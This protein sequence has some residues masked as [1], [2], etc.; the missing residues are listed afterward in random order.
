MPPRGGFTWNPYATTSRAPRPVSWSSTG[1]RNVKPGEDFQCDVSLPESPAAGRQPGW[2]LGRKYRQPSPTTWLDVATEADYEFV[3]ALGGSAEANSEIEGILNVVGG[4]YQSEL[5]LKLQISFQNAWAAEEDPYTAST[6]AGLETE[7][8][9]YWKENYEEDQDYDLVLFWTGRQ[10]LNALGRYSGRVCYTDEAYQPPVFLAGLRPNWGDWDGTQKYQLAAHGIGHLF[11]ATHPTDQ[12]PRNVPCAQTIMHIGGRGLTFCQFSRDE[13][14]SHLASNNGCLDTQTIILQPPSSL[15]ATSVSSSSISLS[16]QDNST[17]ETGFIVQRRRF[18]SG[19]WVQIGTTAADT[20][21]FSNDRLFSEYPYIFRVQALNDSE[22]SAYSNEAEATTPAGTLVIADWRIH[23]IAG[24]DDGDDGPALQAHLE[25]P[26]S[27][28]VDSAGNLYISDYFSNRIRR[29]DTSGTITTIAGTGTRG[30]TGDGGAATGANLNRPGGQAVDNSGNLYIVDGGNHRIRKVD[31]SG[32]ITTVAGTGVRGYSGDGGNAVEAQLAPASVAVDS[33]GN[34][35][36]SDS[37]N[38]RI[39]KVDTSG[40][41]TTVAGTGV[42]GYSGDGGKAVE[43]RLNYPASVEVDTSGNLY[44]TDSSNERIRKVDTSGIITTVAGNGEEGYSGD[45]GPAVEARLESPSG[46]AV[47]GA[48]NL[49]IADPSTHRIR[50]V[51]TSGTITTVAGTGSLGYSGDGGPATGARLYQPGDVAVDSSGNLYI[52]DGLNH[53][54]RKVDTSGIITTAAGGGG[55]YTGDGGLAT[56]ARLNNPGGMALDSSGNLYIADSDHHRIRKVDTSGII[57]TFAGAGERGYSGDGGPAVSAKLAWPRGVAV[58][59]AGNLY[60]ADAGNHRVRRVNSQGIITTVSKGSPTGVVVDASGNLYIADSSYNRIRRL[61]TSGTLTTIAGTGSQGFS[62]DGGPAVEAELRVPNDL[63]VDASGNLYIADTWNRRIRKVDSSGTITTVAGAGL[64]VNSG[65]YGPATEA[66]L[67]WP[68]GVA[69]DGS[70]NLYIPDATPGRIKRVDTSG[71]LTTIA[72]TGVSGF[73]GDGGPAIQAQLHRPLRVAVDSSGNVYI[74]DS[75]N[76]RIRILSTDTTAPTVE[77]IAIASEPLKQATYA[78]GQVIR[79]QVTFSE[80]VAVAGTPQL[81]IEVGGV[82]RAAAFAG[83]MGSTVFFA[84]EVAEGEVDTDG[85]SVGA[86]SLTLGD[87]RIRDLAYN[88]AELSHASLSADTG[89]K[90]EGIRPQLASTGGTVVDGATLTLTYDEALDEESVPPESAFTVTGGSTTRRVTGV[91]VSGSTVLLT[92]DPEVVSGETGIQVSYQV[93][94]ETAVSPVW[95]EVGNEALGLSNQAVTNI[96]RPKVLTVEISS[97][98]GT[99]RTY[100]EGDEIRVAVTFS[101]TVEVTGTPQV[102]LELGGGLRTAAYESG[103]GT[104]A[105]VFEYE[106]AEGESDTDGVGVEAD[107]LS[108]G[109]IKDTANNAAELDHDGLAAEANHKVDGVKPRLAS[110]GGAV[111]NGTT[112]TLTYDE[113]LDGSSTPEADDFTVT[114]G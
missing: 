102:S 86:D 111:V 75:R 5:L 56:G 44:I 62:G 25:T 92:V 49:Y 80:A 10:G 38:H 103:S 93:P 23:T 2:R 101:G 18:G 94:T 82:D 98:P 54:I 6:T 19:M 85:V 70:G 51:D 11:G 12:I 41:I 58:D 96:T 33:A 46:I 32:T 60:I 73:N 15:S 1:T 37:G 26:G 67:S 68:E 110:N 45:G 47:D 35:Y 97:D 14:A 81:A 42:R 3:Q 39:R 61:D 77:S 20:T 72:G 57:T 53:R 22:S 50:K 65:G 83:G 88:D 79:A 55:G 34:L 84:Y 100:A 108:G 71:T 99:D 76:D 48:G 9:S 74:A 64:G 104:A 40:T 106:V 66:V 4:V 91:G 90:V 31:T 29:V 113:P 16:W 87:G 114:G 112:L 69:V 28:A 78:A 43:A 30:Y 95:D 24:G 21:T 89:H 8:R 7:F 36:I 59:G 52:S 13:I 109:T 27:V 63:T 105:L 17:N 107:S